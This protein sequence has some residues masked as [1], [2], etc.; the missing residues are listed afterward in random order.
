LRQTL[1]ELGLGRLHPSAASK[2]DFQLT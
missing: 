2:P 1:A